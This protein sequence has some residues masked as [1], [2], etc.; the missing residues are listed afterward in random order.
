MPQFAHRRGGAA[1]RCGVTKA[2][3]AA[4]AGGTV[5]PA[6]RLGSRAGS[7]FRIAFS[8]C[9]SAWPGSSPSSSRSV[10][11]VVLH[12]GQ[13]VGLSSGPV[14]R[15]HQE[16]AQ[17]LAEGVVA[18]ERLQFGHD[19]GVAA[20]RKV[21]LDAL[22][23][24]DQP[25]RV[26]AADLVLARTPRS[27]SRR[28]A[29]RARGRAPAGVPRRRSP[30]RLPRPAGAPRRAGART[31]AGRAHPPRPARRTRAAAS[32]ARLRRAS[33]AVARRRPGAP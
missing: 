30:A 2:G 14:E 19:V 7:W 18:D 3:G 8:S 13:R 27:G 23:E 24:R 25:E 4:C 1:V 32:R 15:E 17:A 12:H 6:A 11:R 9:C 22:L 10:A 29:R 33:C 28:A 21:G 26:Q 16:P 31:A 20:D 5:A